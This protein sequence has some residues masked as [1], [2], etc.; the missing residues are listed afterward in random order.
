LRWYHYD[1]SDPAS[2]Q[3][4]AFPTGSNAVVYTTATEERN[5]GL[6]PKFNLSY[7][8]DKDLLLYATAAKG[9]RPGGAEIPLPVTSGVAVSCEGSLQALYN[10]TSFV[11]SPTGVA[12]DS[13]W[14][15]ELG[16][17][18][19]LFDGRLTINGAGYYSRWNGVQQTIALSCGFQFFGNAGDAE[20]YGGEIELNALLAQGLVLSANAGYTHSAFVS[21]SLGNAFPPGTPVQDIPNWTSSVSLNYR[22]SL[23]GQLAFT[24]RLENNYVG[25]R[26]DATY[27]VNSLPSYDLTNLRFGVEGER[28]KAV[29]FARNLFDKPAV[30]SNAPQGLNVAIPTFNRLVVSQPRTI[31]IDL[32]YQWQ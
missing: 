16:E 10:T 13:V 11:P 29:L 1:S 2:P 31:G 9:F 6:N 25:T 28:W 32:S 23:S 22:H 26:T 18:A 4:G 12:P 8:L 27:T 21:E 15:Y 7:E 17:K 3:S 5:S 14:S 24:A 20:I 19:T 30:L